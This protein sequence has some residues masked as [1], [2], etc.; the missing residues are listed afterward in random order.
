MLS[1]FAPQ[2]RVRKHRY[3]Y[4]SLRVRRMIVELQRVNRWLGDAWILDTL[5]REIAE[6]NLNRFNT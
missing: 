1:R 5:L 3:R 4:L 2:L 6:Q